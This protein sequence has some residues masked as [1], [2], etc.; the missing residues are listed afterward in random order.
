MK[1]FNIIII[2]I[3]FAIS[4][5]YNQIISYAYFCC[6]N[7]V[8][9]F[10]IYSDV[11]KQKRSHKNKYSSFSKVPIMDSSKIGDIY[12]SSKPTGTT[13]PNQIN[14]SNINMLLNTHFDPSDPYSFGFSCIGTF[15]GAHGIKGELKLFSSLFVTD[16]LN[17]IEIIQ[18]L[19]KLIYVKHPHRRTPRPA[20]LSSFRKSTANKLYIIKLRDVNDR[21]GAEY[22][23]RYK[24]Y[25]KRE[26]MNFSNP[27]VDVAFSVDYGTT[28]V[29]KKIK[30]NVKTM[31]STGQNLDY[32]IK[33][34]IGMNCYIH[35]SNWTWTCSDD[36]VTSQ[37]SSETIN[38]TKDKDYDNSLQFSQVIPLPTSKC[39]LYGV[40]VDVLPPEVLCSSDQFV[41]LM[42]PLL[43]LERTNYSHHAF[44]TNRH[45]DSAERCLVPLVTP[46]IVA[47][48]DLPSKVLLL[49]NIPGLIESTT[50][51]YKK[52]YHIRGYLKPARGSN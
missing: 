28:C 2:S 18:K 43:V 35:S 38:N 10:Q 6:H 47:N 21:S 50:F 30:E 41:P 8:K 17:Q 11:L 20:L 33:D 1:C 51:H 19:G 24:V 44:S 25:L 22:F 32:Y 49:N 15:T 45:L 34:L 4:I 13:V 26:F 40:V 46:E 14:D 37:T 27:S 48:I 3:T 36:E 16:L 31:I 42:H 12:T 52:K 9:N 39:T 23:K 5:F 7:K 29:Q